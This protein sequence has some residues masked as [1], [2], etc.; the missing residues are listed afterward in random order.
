MNA[1]T[2]LAAALAGLCLH[3]A[4]AAAVTGAEVT[5]SG[6]DALALSWSSP[7]PVDV[8]E[9]DRPDA[10]PTGARLLARGSR[11][12]AFAIEHA[13]QARRYFLLVDA[14][15]HATLKVAERLV[16]LEQGSNFRDVGGY[17]AAGGT[18]VRWGLIYRSGAQAMLT[19]DD[20]ARLRGMGLAQLVDLRSKE[21]R[22]L[23]PT[24]IDGVPYTA[25]GYSMADMMPGGLAKLRNGSELYRNFPHLFAPQLKVLFAD[26]LGGRAPIVYNCSAGQDRTG[27][28]TAMILS[29]LGVPREAIYADYQLSTRYRRPQFEAPKVDLAAHPNNI[30]AQMFAHYNDHPE[31]RKA[32]PLV[33]ADGRPYLAGAFDEIDAKWGSVDAYLRQEAGLTDADIAR[34]RA[35]YLE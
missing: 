25:I 22:E 11:A 27:F 34:L 14:R 5:R 17:P 20:V 30:A 19:A 31:L 21:E 23:A 3:T 9:A 13:G 2:I 15:D 4:A 32:H 28:A 8:Y 33:E 12:G 6:A 16:P 7:D 29:A 26:L 10:P 18:H 24:A 35:L 1:R